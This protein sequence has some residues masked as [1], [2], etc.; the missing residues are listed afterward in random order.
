[1]NLRGIR[2]STNAASLIFSVKSKKSEEMAT[3]WLQA[4]ENLQQ[5]FQGKPEVDLLF[6]KDFQWVDEVV[7]EATALF[8]KDTSQNEADKTNESTSSDIAPV[9]LPQTPRVRP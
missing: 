3:S 1:M 9:L 5:Q 2:A 7:A 4:L 8:K 6:E